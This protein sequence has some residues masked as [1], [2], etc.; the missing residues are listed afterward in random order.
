MSD[1]WY[2]EIFNNRLI[3]NFSRCTVRIIGLVVGIAHVGIG[4]VGIA[5]VGIALV[6]IGTASLHGQGGALVPREKAKISMSVIVLCI[7]CIFLF[8]CVNCNRWPANRWTITVYLIKH[9]NAK[10][11]SCAALTAS[12][13]SFHSDLTTGVAK[14]PSLSAEN[15]I[16]GKYKRSKNLSFFSD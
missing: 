16:N 13:F 12:G 4:T 11:I 10:K 8:C 15:H 6:G 7:L 2:G 1:F 3:P 14:M 9:K 5:P